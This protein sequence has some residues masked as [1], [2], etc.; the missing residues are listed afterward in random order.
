MISTSTYF[1]A[2]FIACCYL[3]YAHAVTLLNHEHHKLL[4]EYGQL[5]ATKISAEECHRSLVQQLDSQS[6][7]VWI[8]WLL[9]ERLGL[10]P[11]GS[12]KMLFIHIPPT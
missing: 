6:D 4:E 12:T 3:V 8:E 10:V 5:S 2:L 7:L 1:T 11:E 9:M